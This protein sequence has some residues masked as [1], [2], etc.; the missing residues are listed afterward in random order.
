MQVVV[1]RLEKDTQGRL[2][3]VREV[4]M[5]RVANVNA[6]GRQA[7]AG[8]PARAGRPGKAQIRKIHPVKKKTILLKLKQSPLKI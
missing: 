4:V 5:V 1:E 8:R 2:V 6:K 3:L 7:G